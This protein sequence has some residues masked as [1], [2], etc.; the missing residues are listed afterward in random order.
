[1]VHPVFNTSG[2]VIRHEPKQTH[3][4]SMQVDGV[5]KPSVEADYLSPHKNGQT[6][7]IKV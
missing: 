1:M 7:D 2:Q 5:V 4:H 6:L 3:Q